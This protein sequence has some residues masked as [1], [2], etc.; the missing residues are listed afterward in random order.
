MDGVWTRR[1]AE[2]PSGATHRHR[3]VRTAVPRPRPRRCCSRTARRAGVPVRRAARAE[4]LSAYALCRHRFIDEAL[5]AS[6]ASADGGATQVVILGAGYDA[7]AYRFAA[8]IGARPVYEVDLA[9]LSR[10]KA[11]IVAAHPDRFGHASVHRVEVD[12]RTESLE[13]R[14]RGSGLLPGE[15]TFVAW[16]GVTPYLSRA[17]VVATLATLAGLCGEG[18]VLAMDFWEG[19][20]G[21]GL[22][23]P[24]RRVGARAIGLV[25]EPVTFGLPLVG[26]RALLDEHGWQVAE[27]N[28]ATELAR[29]FATDDRPVERSLYVL[30]AQRFSG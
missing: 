18:S 14:L 19:A 20:D 1:R 15:P 30:A 6:L 16:E 5:L 22:L 24:L 27:V 29:R 2:P 10:R 17:A 21:A 12:F 13:R 28:D 25:G 23:A 26:A 3:R 4:R 9:P 11:A 7:R 8:Q